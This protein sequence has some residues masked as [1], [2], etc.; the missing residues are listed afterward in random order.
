MSYLILIQTSFMSTQ[1]HINYFKLLDVWIQHCRCF[2]HILK[3]SNCCFHT[4]VLLSPKMDMLSSYHMLGD[5]GASKVANSRRNFIACK[6]RE[7]GSRDIRELRLSPFFVPE[8]CSRE[9]TVQPGVS[10]V[11]HLRGGRCLELCLLVSHFPVN[12]SE[13][14]HLPP[15][16]PQRCC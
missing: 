2:P 3:F 15:P 11:Q 14:S 13:V 4:E 5:H 9:Q 12:I 1:F 8:S 10:W 7:L 6:G 16:P